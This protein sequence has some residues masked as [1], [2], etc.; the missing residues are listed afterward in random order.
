MKSKTRIPARATLLTALALSA[1]LGRAQTT[2][3]AQQPAMPATVA[4]AKE[5]A[6]QLSAF[7]VSGIRFGIEKAIATKQELSLIVEAI[8][9]EDIGKLPDV[10]IAES[11]ARL[12]GLAAQRVAGRAQ[13]ISIRGLSPDFANTLLNGREQVSTGDNRGVEFD[14][15]P[16]E[17]ISAV[18]VF[19]TP[20][21]KLVAQGLSG[22]LNLETVKPL[23]FGKRIVAFN[24]RYETNSLDNLGAGSKHTGSRVSATYVDQFAHNTIGVA[25]GYAHLDS[26]ILAQE[27]AAYSWNN[28]TV[29]TGV[30]A[31]TFGP[32]G[33]QVFARSGTNTRDGFIGI[34]QWRP[35]ATFT[36]V[37]DVYHSEFRR[38]ETARGLESSIRLTPY[39]ATKIVNNAL[40]GG[41]VTG[42]NPL[43]RNIYNNRLDKLS[44]IGWNNQYRSENWVLS[45]DLS[46]SKA[47][48]NELN[49]ET[50]AQNRS[51]AGTAGAA[52][53]DTIT[54]DF[55]GTLPSAIFGNSYSD[56]SR[57]LVGPTSF[58]AGYGKVPK[59]TDELTS[60]KVTASRALQSVF[61]TVE[62]GLNYSDR[63]KNKAQPEASLVQPNWQ[64]VNSA[65][66]LANTS[67]G[68]AGGPST[69]SWSVPALYPTGYAPF[70][71]STTAAA[72]L[73]QKTWIVVEKIS[74][75][76]AQANFNQR[77]GEVSLRGNL[78]IQAKVV[79]QSSSANLFD[80]VARTVR[81]N[82][83]G[84]TYTDYLPS[85][86]FTFDFGHQFLVRAAVAKQVARPR[87]DQLKAAFEFNVT[88]GLPT[89]SGGNPRLDPWRA[90]SYDLSIEKYFAGNKGYV[91][92]A[93]FQKNLTSYIYDLVDPNYN[94]SAYTQGLAAP[95][96]S[97]T[98]RFSQPLNGSGGSLKGLEATVSVPFELLSSA[99][100]GFG[101]VAS[102]SR[103]SSAITV[104]N[105]NLGSAISLPGLSRTVTSLTFYFEKSG[106]SARVSRRY[107][108]DFI[109]EISG[110]GVDRSLRFVKG[111]GI[112][113]A[114]LGYEFKAGALKGLGIVVQASNLNNTAFQTYQQFKERISEFQKYG[115]TF[116]SGVNYKF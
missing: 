90:T 15:Y 1:V 72:F 45:G 58:G 24:A 109:G 60:A 48:R 41:T 55:S 38:E 37:I 80:S 6:V 26:P 76:Y 19:K 30:P 116:L 79:D 23:S 111:E 5:E 107:R 102:A 83:D 94:F 9:A 100:N 70:L 101:V 88:N 64:S 8:S 87:L 106:F 56:P 54:Y 42:A 40:V 2:T 85:A 74:T 12:P 57:T 68:F 103:N 10:S 32:N 97:N 18:T 7:N 66:L 65:T 82:R 62:V 39:T 36:S 112:I 92:L 43:V 49:M 99:L 113:D 95:V 89:G 11:I 110:F 22:T 93:G 33:I 31:G 63:H 61:E 77:I 96:T 59:V 16:S 108:S 75:P 34:L 13:V 69:L 17:L 84:K 53:L 98:G 52:V 86:N 105:T 73:V 91:S 29:R 78:G 4:A 51:A 71:P 35:S 44:A 115:R 50:Q 47:Q 21:A 104:D 28:T 114:Q 67:L 20:D 46:Y 27:Y 14:Q 25:F 3:T 81:L